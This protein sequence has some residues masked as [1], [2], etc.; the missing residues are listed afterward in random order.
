MGVVSV[1]ASKRAQANK[2]TQA[3]SKARKALGVKGFLAM[4]ARARPA[5]HFSPRPA[6]STRNKC[7]ISRSGDDRSSYYYRG[8]PNYYTEVVRT[9]VVFSKGET[10]VMQDDIENH[11][12]NV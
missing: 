3:C 5:S 6:P 9:F 12:Q 8:G 4:A 2:W 10:I 1:K 7:A 11:F